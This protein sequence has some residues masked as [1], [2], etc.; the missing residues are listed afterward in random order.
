MVCIYMYN[1]YN[2][3]WFNHKK[4][5]EIAICD[6]MGEP[7]EHC[8]KWNKSDK[9]QVSY[10]LTYVWNL[11]KKK[12]NHTYTPFKKEKKES[13]LS[14]WIQ[15]TNWW[16]PEVG[17]SKMDECNQKVQISNYKISPGGAMYSMVATVNKSVL[18]ISKLLY[19]E[20][21][22]RNAGLEEAQGGI[23]IARRNT[24]NLRYTDDTTLMPESEEE[25]KSRSMKVKEWKS[26]L[27]TQRSKN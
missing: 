16:S 6:N 27:T 18:H 23:K 7:W 24:N 21:I 12:N 25:L 17:V 11:K 10:N 22:M 13:K 14:S 26:W 19:A 9:N 20:Y 15:R 4:E 5:W 3:I 1:T 8:V 2:E